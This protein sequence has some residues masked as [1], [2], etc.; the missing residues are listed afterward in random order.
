MVDNQPNRLTMIAP[1]TAMP[2][3]AQEISLSAHEGKL[4]TVRGIPQGGWIY[5]ARITSGQFFRANVGVVL[6]NAKGEVLALERKPRGSGQ[7]QMVQ[8]GLDEGEEPREAAN[9]ELN[10][11]LGLDPELHA[12]FV[13]EHPEWM[14]YELPARDRRPKHGRGQVQKWLLFRFKGK[15]SDIDLARSARD[16]GETQEFCAFK[17]TTLERLAKETWE[18]R[19]PIYMRLTTDFGKHLSK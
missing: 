19:R 14:A 10:E 17:W 4:L 2:P 12:E 16:G 7:W 15:D 18:L 8:G 9:R 13:A 3:E 1:Q 11:E 6:V 5:S